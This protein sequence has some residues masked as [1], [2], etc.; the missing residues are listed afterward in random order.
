V[1]TASGAVDLLAITTFDNGT[2]WLATL[3][4]TFA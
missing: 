3:A 4:K 2:T 1:S